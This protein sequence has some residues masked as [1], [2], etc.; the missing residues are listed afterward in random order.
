M[1]IS[2]LRKRRSIRRFSQVQIETEKLDTLVEAMLRAPSSRGFDPWEFIVVTDR[3]VLKKLAKAK[4][5]GSAFLDNAA[6]AIVVCADPKRSDVWIED[7]SIAAIFVHL[8]AASL[9]LGSCWIQIRERS[10]SAT[11]SAES[12]VL[13]TLAIPQ[14]LRVESIVAVGYPD[15]QKSGHPKEKLE[16]GKVHLNGYG[17]PYAE[18]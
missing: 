4:E 1:F 18:K 12:Y 16:L 13:E 9:G 17:R 8:A 15:E 5:H 11:K 14:T 10:H 2:L 6:C 7:A 3:T